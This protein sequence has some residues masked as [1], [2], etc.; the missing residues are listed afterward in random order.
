MDERICVQWHDFKENISTSLENLRKDNDFADVTLACEDGK[1]VAA[2]K[3]ILTS[4]SPVFWNILR[5][6]R[7]AHPII[8]M[9]DM[10]SID[11]L[12]ILD[13]IY[14]GKTF[15]AEERA[16]SFFAIAEDLRLKA[17]LDT[18]GRGPEVER[19]TVIQSNEAVHQS[20]QK[21]EIKSP[22]EVAHPDQD[23]YEPTK[24]KVDGNVAVNLSEDLQEHEVQTNSTSKITPRIFSGDLQENEEQ[25]NS[26]METNS[27]IT[28]KI[29]SGD[30]LEYEQQ[31]NSMMEKTS[32][33]MQRNGEMKLIY[34]CKVCGKEGENSN[35][36]SHIQTRHIEGACIPCN[37]C[38]KTFR[39][40]SALSV[41]KWRKHK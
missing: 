4:S 32:K 41:H 16:N 25:A 35:I 31:T 20:V 28:S 39:S 24:S 2:H 6:Y 1:Q 13:F 17:F 34:I 9:K 19:N 33:K 21:G 10:S 11:L 27:Q 15:I 38:Q 12:A 18:T 7:H 22:K 30:L 3:V 36:K 14:C 23:I 29:F 40:N 37:L 26:T 8:Y 5:E